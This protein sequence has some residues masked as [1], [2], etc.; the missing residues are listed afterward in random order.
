M[1]SPLLGENWQLVTDEP[2]ELR[3]NRLKFETSGT[4]PIILEES[5]EEFTTS[6]EWNPSRKM[7]N[8]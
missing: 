5:I 7:S 4:L 6:N 3:N 2:V 8:M 1:I